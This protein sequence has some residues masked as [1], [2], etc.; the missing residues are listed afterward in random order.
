MVVNTELYCASL[1]HIPPDTCIRL[2]NKIVRCNSP[3]HEIL[4]EHTIQHVSMLVS[5][6]TNKIPQSYY[7]LLILHS[8]ISC[9]HLAE[10][11]L[12]KEYAYIH[13][14]ILDLSNVLKTYPGHV[15]GHAINTG[16]YELYASI[17][18]HIH[19]TQYCI[20]SILRDLDKDKVNSFI[21]IT[22]VHHAID[23]KI[24]QAIVDLATEENIPAKNIVA[25]IDCTG[26]FL[27]GRD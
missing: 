20:K 18:P 24:Y 26:S 27:F 5:S 6:L 10:M 22:Y 16:N 8:K 9:R 12:Q 2:F 19:P 11:L 25:K 21:E 17:I 4:L 14:S 23:Q 15:I 1:K 7:V 3:G 13:Q